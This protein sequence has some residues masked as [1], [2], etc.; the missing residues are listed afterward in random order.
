VAKFLGFD[1]VAIEP[2]PHVAFQIGEITADV[3]Q[4]H[5]VGHQVQAS[6]GRRILL[7]I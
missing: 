6:V 3:A 2:S 1:A 5:N 7:M 4:S